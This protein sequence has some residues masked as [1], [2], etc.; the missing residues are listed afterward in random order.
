V[1]PPARQECA[2][3][4]SRRSMVAASKSIAEVTAA[5]QSVTG[6][7]VIDRTGL[8]GQF[9]LELR[10]TPTA[11]SASPAPGAP[12]ADDGPSIFTALQEQLGLKLESA[13]GSADVL[14]VDAVKRPDAN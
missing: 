11:D 9:D 4:A 1:T 13:R 10:W 6:R 5:L 3:I 14:I 12:P 7:P 2:L 8:K